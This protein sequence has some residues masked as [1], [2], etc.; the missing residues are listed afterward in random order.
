MRGGRS[1]ANSRRI[2]GGSPLHGRRLAE[3][4]LSLFL[5]V[6]ASG[7]SLAADELRIISLS[8]STSAILV[9]LGAG[10]AVVGSDRFSRELPG[11]ERAASLGGLFTPDLERT[12]ELEPTLVLGVRSEQQRWFFEHLRA[13]GIETH[14]VEPKKLA[15]VLDTYR[16]IADLVG[17]PAAGQALVARVGRELEQ[18]RSE[19]ANRPR[20]SVALVVHREPLYVV[21][22]GSFVSELIDAAG[23]QNVFADLAAPYPQVSLEALAERR[24]DVLVDTTLPERAERSEALHYWTRFSWVRRVELIPTGVLTVPGPDL[25]SAARLLLGALG[26]APTPA[27][28]R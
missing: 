25:A 4:W 9:A 16:T 8:P 24:P 21:G 17:R 13:R 14:E 27:L 19:A 12:V 15:E 5:L 22:G 20:R 23:G 18:I 11:L 2:P 3:L 28:A 6:C 10:E 1:G 26:S 7:R